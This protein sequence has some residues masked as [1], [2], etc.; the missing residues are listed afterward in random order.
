MK[1]RIDLGKAAEAE[2]F[3]ALA[4]SASR[5]HRNATTARL[6]F[7]QAQSRALSGL[8]RSEVQDARKAGAEKR[9]VTCRR[10]FLRVARRR[11]WANLVHPDKRLL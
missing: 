8:V 9:R 10:C 11:A 6:P 7:T 5:T 2:G 1:Q 4:L 3:G